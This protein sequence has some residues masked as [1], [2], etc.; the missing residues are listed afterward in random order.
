MKKSSKLRHLSM[1]SKKRRIRKKNEKRLNACYDR[2]F[3][4]VDLG[5]SG[6]NYFV[7][8]CTLKS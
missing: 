2:G 6:I 3:K 7:G 1:H 5:L 8:Y 4:K